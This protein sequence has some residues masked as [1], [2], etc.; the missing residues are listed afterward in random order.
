MQH[1]QLFS[2][3]WISSSVLTI[4]YHHFS[5]KYVTQLKLSTYVYRDESFCLSQYCN[6][7]DYLKLTLNISKIQI[8]SS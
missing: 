2:M 5:L 4:H 6:D 3:R 8:E 7:F 1:I